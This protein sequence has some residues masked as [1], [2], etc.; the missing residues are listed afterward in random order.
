MLT[1]HSTFPVFWNFTAGLRRRENPRR[2]RRHEVA[3]MKNVSAVSTALSCENM[4]WICRS[5]PKAALQVTSPIFDNDVIEV[6]GDGAILRRTM[7]RPLAHFPAFH[8]RKWVDYGSFETVPMSPTRPTPNTR[9][10]AFVIRETGIV[11]TLFSEEEEEKRPFLAKGGG[12]SY[13]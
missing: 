9:L 2:K 11:D 12:G 1:H 5:S 7:K 3:F 13:A 8:F 4:R 10:D 6:S